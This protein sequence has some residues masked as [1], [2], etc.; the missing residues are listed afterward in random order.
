MFA[1]CNLLV[2]IIFVQFSAYPGTGGQQHNLQSMVL[3]V[4]QQPDIL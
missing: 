2:A 4:M 1:S 3:E